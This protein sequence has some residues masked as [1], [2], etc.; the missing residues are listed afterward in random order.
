MEKPTRK[1]HHLS[2]SFLHP[3][4]SKNHSSRQIAPVCVGS[5]RDKLKRSC[6][7]CLCLVFRQVPRGWW[8]CASVYLV[9]S[10]QMLRTTTCFHCRLTSNLLRS[11]V[12]SYPLFAIKLAC[13]CACFGA[14]NQSNTR[15]Q[16]HI[17]RNVFPRVQF[18]SFTHTH[19]HGQ[20]AAD[21]EAAN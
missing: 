12:P 18:D 8:L 16:I 15:T 11:H 5:V 3:S 10:T 2:A 21:S 14:A 9:T 20:T 19:A 7:S 17:N 6:L 13:D 4:S 1:K